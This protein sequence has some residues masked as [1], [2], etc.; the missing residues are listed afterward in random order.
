MLKSH[1]PKDSG[2]KALNDVVVCGALGTA[3]W[4]GFETCYRSICQN[5]GVSLA[6]GTDPDKAFSASHT[7]KKAN[8]LSIER[9]ILC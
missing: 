7:G 8:T 6:G 3:A 4:P 5:V 9:S 1:V 2:S